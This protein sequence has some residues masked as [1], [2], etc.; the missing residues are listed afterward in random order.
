MYRVDSSKNEVINQ[1]YK[2]TLNVEK[3]PKEIYEL[4][5]PE[6]KSSDSYMRLGRTALTNGYAKFVEMTY[7]KAVE[8]HGVVKV[9]NEFKKQMNVDNSTDEIILV[10]LVIDGIVYETSFKPVEGG[11]P[12]KIDIEL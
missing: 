6:P 1:A 2:D 5:L 8:R 9:I 10:P 12:K 4:M 3:K 7:S 11:V